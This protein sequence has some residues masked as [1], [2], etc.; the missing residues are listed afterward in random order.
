[1]QRKSFKVHGAWV[2]YWRYDT[3]CV[4]AALAD[5]LAER[6]ALNL[7]DVEWHASSPGKAKQIIVPTVGD[8]WFDPGE[9]RDRVTEQHGTAGATCDECGVW[10]WLP[11]NF[12]PVPPMHE[13][14]LP[15]LCDIPDLAGHD[16]AASPEWFGDGSKA[17]RKTLFRRELA[18][19]RLPHLRADLGEVGAELHRFRRRDRL[20]RVRDQ[21]E[22]EAAMRELESRVW[23][24]RHVVLEASGTA[25]E[26]A[27]AAAEAI[28]REVGDEKLGPYSE[29]EWGYLSGQLSAVR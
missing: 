1:L 26:E 23:H 19:R 8:R 9:L 7:V 13:L 29:F 14:T 4:E 5:R 11:L 20:P 15:P 25:S 3:I 18:S 27:A 16:V 28:R 6:F 22:V 21:A 24:E 2:P 12:E 10:R 17:F